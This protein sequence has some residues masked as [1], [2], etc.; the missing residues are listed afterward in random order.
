MTIAILDECIETLEVFKDSE[1]CLKTLR[2]TITF[3]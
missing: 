2:S 1:E 3:L